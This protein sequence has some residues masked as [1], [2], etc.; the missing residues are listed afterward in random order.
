[1]LSK[2][3]KSMA[4]FDFPEDE[5]TEIDPRAIEI[6]TLFG[7]M[8]KQTKQTMRTIFEKNEKEEKNEKKFWVTT[9]MLDDLNFKG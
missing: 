5:K 3:V 2:T 7:Q 4:V 9:S 8:D 1:M 6:A